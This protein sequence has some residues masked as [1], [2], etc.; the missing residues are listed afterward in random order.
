MK[1]KAVR[2]IIL[3]PEGQVL[4]IR[5]QE[6]VTGR[7]LWVA[8]GGGL[9][10]DEP[11][12]ICLSREIQEETGQQ[13]IGIGPLIW[14][15]KHT[16]DWAGQRLAQSETYYLIRANWFEPFMTGNPEPVELA[17]FREFRWWTVDEIKASTDQFAPSRIADFIQNIIQHGPPAEPVDVGV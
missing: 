8:P 14:T 17:A 2:G 3:A 9:E 5:V 4:L 12:E 15:R 10:P 7:Q 16:F 13:N 6:P 1:R 11:P